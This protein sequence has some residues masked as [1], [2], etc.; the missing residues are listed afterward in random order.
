MH[1]SVAWAQLLV[2]NFADKERAINLFHKL[3]TIRLDA[4]IKRELPGIGRTIEKFNS[5]LVADDLP[6]AWQD[7]VTTLSNPEATSHDTARLLYELYD[8]ELS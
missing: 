2:D 3:E 7:A 5:L 1:Q 8:H 4:N 6:K